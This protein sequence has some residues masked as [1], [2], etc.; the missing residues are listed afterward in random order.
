[1]VARAYIEF[2]VRVIGART[3]PA[4]IIVP[5]VEEGLTSRCSEG[6]ETW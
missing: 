6:G 3:G 4:R 1:M 2:F 5:E